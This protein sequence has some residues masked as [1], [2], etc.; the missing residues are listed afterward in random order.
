MPTAIW[1]ASDL[2]AFGVIHA[3]QKYGLQVPTDISIIWH[4]D[5]FF[6][7][8]SLLSLTTFQIPKMELGELAVQY[9]L[10]LMHSPNTSLNMK[11]ILKPTLI[12]RNSTRKI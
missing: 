12:I 11:Q 7:Q 5:L 2:M 8:D 1:C 4:D 9:A 3:L 10:E 6:S